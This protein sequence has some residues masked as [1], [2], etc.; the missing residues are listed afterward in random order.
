MPVFVPST[1]DSNSPCDLCVI[2]VS[3]SNS[4]IP[5]LASD[6]IIGGRAL[7]EDLI[8][9]VSA[10]ARKSEFNGVILYAT[11]THWEHVLLF[12]RVYLLDR[13]YTVPIGGVVAVPR[14]A[15]AALLDESDNL[16]IDSARI[17]HL[18]LN[19]NATLQ[20]LYAT[21]TRHLS[22][23]SK[24]RLGPAWGHPGRNLPVSLCAA[25]SVLFVHCRT[26]RPTG[27]HEP[28]RLCTAPGEMGEVFLVA[29]RRPQRDRHRRRCLDLVGG[30]VLTIPGGTGANCRC[31][32]R[33]P[34]D[35]VPI[36]ST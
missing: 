24:D 31:S 28:R 35:I 18:S 25:R 12:D 4:K 5:D 22:L 32:A 26:F 11:N 3:G 2:S 23:S 13:M 30:R 8:L 21:Q 16:C 7:A 36:L 9:I 6:L 14:T 34:S 27:L 33:P 10:H 19:P 1:P 29:H 20:Q 15:D 17:A